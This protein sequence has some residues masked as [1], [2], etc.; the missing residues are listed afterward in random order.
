MNNTTSK[1]K[2][3]IPNGKVNPPHPQIGGLKKKNCSK[4]PQMGDLGG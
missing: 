2:A 4:V 1:W 3:K